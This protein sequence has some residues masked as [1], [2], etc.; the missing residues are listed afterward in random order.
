MNLFHRGIFILSA[1]VWFIILWFIPEYHEY[2]HRM[3]LLLRFIAVAGG[4]FLLVIALSRHDDTDD[5][6]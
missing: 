5:K 6:K 2:S 4:I 3:A 1:I